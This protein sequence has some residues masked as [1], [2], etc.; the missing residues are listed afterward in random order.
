LSDKFPGDG[1][2][3]YSIGQTTVKGLIN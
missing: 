1:T 3:D 2:A